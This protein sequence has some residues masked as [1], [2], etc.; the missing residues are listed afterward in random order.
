[1]RVVE[2]S[3]KTPLGALGSLTMPCK[4]FSSSRDICFCIGF[5]CVLLL[6]TFYIVSIGIPEFIVFG[7]QS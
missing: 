4:H 6:I 5:T 7:C 3:I 2:G 1:M